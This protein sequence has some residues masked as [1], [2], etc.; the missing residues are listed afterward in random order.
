LSSP[1]KT[2]SSKSENKKES[3]G[4]DL[5]QKIAEDKRVESISKEKVSSVEDELAQWKNN[6]LYLKA[7]FE[8]YKKQMNKERTDLVK[9]GSERLILALLDVLDILDRSLDIKVTAENVK[10][11]VTGVRLTSEE[12]T[13][14]LGRFGVNGTDPRGQVFDPT[15]HEALSSEESSTVPPGH[16]TQVFKKAYKLHDRVIR[17]AQ[18]VVACEPNGSNN[19]NSNNET[20]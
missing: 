15:S 4:E 7:E 20:H 11:F 3:K 1:K 16:I 10:D 6:Y 9:Y 8:N 12:L 17:P 2:K 5:E 14:T 13:N 18:V 19:G